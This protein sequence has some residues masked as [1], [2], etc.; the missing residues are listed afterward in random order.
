MERSVLACSKVPS[1]QLHGESEETMRTV[2]L[3]D[4]HVAVKPWKIPNTNQTFQAI[5]DLFSVGRVAEWVLED[6]Y[7]CP[8]I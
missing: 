5:M 6:G 3:V 4:L 2:G 1:V 7:S 8:S